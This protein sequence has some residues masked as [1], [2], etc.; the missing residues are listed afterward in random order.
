MHSMSA[1]VIGTKLSLNHLS[2]FWG[3][4]Q[5]AAFLRQSERARAVTMVKEVGADLF[6]VECAD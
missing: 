3:T 6:V 5:D 4:P 2:D 1:Q